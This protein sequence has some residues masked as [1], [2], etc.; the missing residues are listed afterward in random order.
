M[1]MYVC[2]WCVFLC[3]I[4]ETSLLSSEGGIHSV[5]QNTH[6]HTRAHRK[7]RESKAIQRAPFSVLERQRRAIPYMIV[8][9][10]FCGREWNE[11]RK[12]TGKN[13]Q[14]R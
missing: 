3:F 6:T 7:N 12:E 14:E 10:L 13:M 1:S 4:C 2:V 9:S 8:K 11:T 5:I